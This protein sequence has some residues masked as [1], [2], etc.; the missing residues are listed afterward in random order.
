MSAFICARYAFILYYYQNCLLN[1]YILVCQLSRREE[2]PACKVKFL[3]KKEKIFII[4]SVFNIKVS[5]I[6][7]LFKKKINS[8]D[9][10]PYW[11]WVLLPFPESLKIKAALFNFVRVLLCYCVTSRT[12]QIHL[13]ERQETGKEKIEIKINLLL[14]LLVRKTF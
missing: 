10:H 1:H 12:L 13:T 6:H 4:M 9:I 14:H 11:S 7:R 3:F 5:F 2:E 8:I